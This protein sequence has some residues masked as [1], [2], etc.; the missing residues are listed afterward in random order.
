[1]LLNSQLIDRYINC[2][3]KTKAFNER[4]DYLEKNDNKGFK[5]LMSLYTE[6]NYYEYLM[7]KN[8]HIIIEWLCLTDTKMYPPHYK[9]LY[10]KIKERY[11]ETNDNSLLTLL[12]F[13]AKENYKHE[14]AF[15]YFIK[16]INDSNDPW[17]KYGLI[18]LIFSSDF[19]KHKNKR[20]KI[21]IIKKYTENIDSYIE[22]LTKAGIYK[23]L[24]DYGK[25][26]KGDLAIPYY[27]RFIEHIYPIFLEKKLV[28]DDP[29]YYVSHVIYSIAKHYFEKEDYSNC[30]KYFKLF[31]KLPSCLYDT[32]DTENE[33]LWIYGYSLFKMRGKNLESDNSDSDSKLDLES[34]YGYE[35]ILSYFSCK[36]TQEN[37]YKKYTSS[38]NEILEDIKNNNLSLL[39][40]DYSLFIIATAYYK[41]RNYK[42][43][44]E[45][46]EL[47]KD[48]MMIAKCAH[49]L[50][51]Y[52][53]LI[54]SINNA[55][56]KNN[57]EVYDFVGY[58]YLNG[59]E[60]IKKDEIKA[61]RYFLNKKYIRLDNIEKWLVTKC[62]QIKLDVNQPGKILVEFL[63]KKIKKDNT[64][65]IV[66][67][68]LGF[69]K[70]YGIG[71][72]RDIKSSV[73][74]IKIAKQ[75]G[76]IESYRFLEKIKK[77]IIELTLKESLV[78]LDSNDEVSSL[79]KI[80]IDVLENKLDC[81]KLDCDN[82]DCVNSDC[83]NLDCDNSD[84]VNSDCE[85][86]HS[87][88]IDKK[89]IY[90]PNESK[91]FDL[92]NLYEYTY[93]Y[94]CQSDNV[95][96]DYDSSDQY[97]RILLQDLIPISDDKILYEESDEES[98]V[99]V[100]D[101]DKDSDKESD[102]KKCD[103][104]NKSENNLDSESDSEVDITKL[105]I[106]TNKFY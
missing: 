27:K 43:A 22:E 84:C 71:T 3:I 2:D 96:S 10:P 70:Y 57:K 6:N 26:K 69:C 18:N 52:D 50:R 39:N 73:E 94:Y 4:L 12:G 67:Y 25:I 97:I 29:E 44:I 74:Y 53:K 15:E 66:Y 68:L 13:L 48:H 82:L 24:Y 81:D 100:V 23:I 21:K 38:F 62:E 90:V 35:N 46:F 56:K 45:Y 79:L 103:R 95:N 54:D 36:N 7:D 5:L 92:E 30:I 16:S 91:N 51:D 20:D 19:S 14:T 99:E 42:K 83:D 86:N 28:L 65:G 60:K 59:F 33:S 37:I 41:E 61:L 63:E 102:N 88:K 85:S 9:N 87:N 47:R 64:S 58:L 98:D 76:Y 89:N 75:K 8:E 17:A 1:M 49:K 31:F 40:F 34:N 77:E 93:S 106:G 72:K 11:Y 55:Y 80:S 104:E 101:S 105:Y 32:C 78:V